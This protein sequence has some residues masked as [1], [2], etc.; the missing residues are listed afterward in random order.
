MARYICIAR[1]V[2]RCLLLKLIRETGLAK[3]FTDR[4][5]LMI[6]NF[7]ALYATTFRATTRATTPPLLPRVLKKKPLSSLILHHFLFFSA[8]QT[9]EFVW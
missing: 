7:S 5:L 3:R 2:A 8:I 1:K 9:L 6:G 4:M